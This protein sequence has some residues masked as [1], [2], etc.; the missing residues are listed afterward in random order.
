MI[1][2]DVL[3]KTRFSC[4]S[5]SVTLGKRIGLIWL[6]ATLN[7]KSCFTNV[8]SWHCGYWMG[9]RLGLPHRETVD[10]AGFPTGKLV[11]FFS[12]LKNSFAVTGTIII[13]LLLLI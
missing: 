1:F 7:V 12:Q 11:P 10:S 8:G 5:R 2:D 3:K 6:L 13:F 4:R 9:M